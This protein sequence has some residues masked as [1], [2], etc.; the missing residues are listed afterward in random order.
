MMESK[1]SVT[2]LPALIGLKLSAMSTRVQFPHP[3]IALAAALLI[4][5]GL[6]TSALS[7]QSE[8]AINDGGRMRLILM[9]GD[10]KGTYEGA[11]QIEP[12]AGWITYWREPGDSGIPPQ[13][14][15]M[16]GSDFK[17][18]S[19]SYPVPVRIDNG[20]VRDVG[21]EQKVTFPLVFSGPVA[22]GGRLEASAFIGICKNICIPFQAHF[23]VDVSPQTDMGD[24]LI[25]AEA[26]AALPE[27][28]SRDFSV[29]GFSLNDDHSTLHL[30]LAVPKTDEN[31][32]LFVTGPEG[33]LFLDYT[34]VESAPGT[35]SVEMPVARLP[36][37]YDPSGK[38]WSVL[39]VDG[40]RA[41]ESALAFE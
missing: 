11:L 36:E 1:K 10:D 12:N 21:Y 41:M 4:G 30:D 19:I 38:T 23:T 2:G 22:A 25:L 33:T 8:W 15:V 13:V 29:T 16:P 28:P 5:M 40:A 39:V 27:P 20:P 3:F 18:E 24:G 31:P 9:P 7:A 34:V 14:G 17:L 35:L 26:K 32:Q 6:A 37:H